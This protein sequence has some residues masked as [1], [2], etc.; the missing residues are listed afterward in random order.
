L[1]VNFGFAKYAVKKSETGWPR[2]ASQYW[3]Q[4]PP[5]CQRAASIVVNLLLELL[6]KRADFHHSQ[7]LT[8]F[9]PVKESPGGSLDSHDAA[10][11]F[12]NLEISSASR[13]A[14]ISRAQRRV[15]LAFDAL[16][17]VRSFQIDQTKAE[18]RRASDRGIAIRLVTEVTQETLPLCREVSGHVMIR[19]LRDIQQNLVVTESASQAYPRL[20][21]Q[22]LNAQVVHSTNPNLVR[23]NQYL[24]DLLWENSV[25]LEDRIR[26]LVGGKEEGETIVV[27]GVGEVTET[28]LAVL[29]RAKEYCFAY[30]GLDAPSLAVEVEPYRQ[31][32]EMMKAR[33]L[34][35][36]AITEITPSNSPFCKKLMKL[37]ELRHLE[38]SKGNFI[39]TE[40]EFVAA[41]V[42]LMSASPAQC[43][44]YSD[45]PQVVE[46]HRQVF[47]L[48]W[49]SSIPAE[50]RFNQIDRG[51]ANESD[52]RLIR[53]VSEG[54]AV[55]RSLI[56]ACSK[57]LNIIFP[58]EPLL[59]RDDL[60]YFPSAK[61]LHERGIKVRV[62]APVASSE[63]AKR[64]ARAE[65][66]S[67][68]PLN[69][70][71][72]TVDRK[73]MLS[74]FYSRPD[75]ESRLGSVSSYLLTTNPHAVDGMCE[76]FDELWENI[77]L[78]EN[79]ERTRREA[80][81]FQ[82]VLTHDI[83]NQNQISRLSAEM[84]SEELSGNESVRSLT[85]SL[86]EAVNAETLL[87]ERARKFARIVAGRGRALY[88][89]HLFS[90]IENSLAE[91]KELHREKS[92]NANLATLHGEKESIYVM[93]D[94]LLDEVFI[95]VFSNCIRHTSSKDVFIEVCVEES[96]PPV[97]REKGR[98][99]GSLSGGPCWVVSI[100]DHGPGIPERA[101]RSIFRRFE[102]GY[103][104]SGLGLSIVNELVVGRYGGAIEIEDRVRGDH[105]KGVRLKIY[106]KRS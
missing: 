29:G 70:C 76:I 38:G 40:K 88:R 57:E 53:D 52:A 97:Y 90:V 103:K 102:N 79:Y 101:K 26:A 22:T 25:P 58:S 100:A 82:D 3:N 21:K 10:T 45:S 36:R 30:G 11:V 24:F 48:L 32:S 31:A 42:P 15:D 7:L 95:N 72:M 41:D 13:L 69:A 78:K 47:D 51:T 56:D 85:E 44:I 74:V 54:L 91:A 19:H 80:A 34:T 61:K 9:L 62:L 94:A 105:G 18:L 98:V 5:N 106:L 63:S 14:A 35:Q 46:Q 23:Q 87:I 64:L 6:N 73:V 50:T 8:F 81:L 37:C 49:K 75:D 96:E 55:G 99:L 104:G 33:G 59:H 16:S 65:W 20:E 4:V 84:L 17:L 1:E 77:E 39:V 83:A 92:V 67:I 68:E 71:F 2:L 93:A 60:S 66:K 27:H 89:V 43:V 12:D 28:V 86:K